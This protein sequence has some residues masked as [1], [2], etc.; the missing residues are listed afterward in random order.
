[1]ET[2][3]AI[4]AK[5]HSISF[6]RKCKGTPII[7]TEKWNLIKWLVPCAALMASCLSHIYKVCIIFFKRC[8]AS[9]YRGRV[10]SGAAISAARTVSKKIICSEGTQSNF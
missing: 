10:L 2:M 8:Q 1:M 6:I 3:Q 4:S 9:F 7:G 5:L